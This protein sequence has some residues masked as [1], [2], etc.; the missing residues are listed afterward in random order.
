[1]PCRYMSFPSIHGS[2][3]DL[4]LQTAPSSTKKF[5]K[6]AQRLLKTDHA[7]IADHLITP[8][9][10]IWLMLTDHVPPTPSDGSTLLNYLE[11]TNEWEYNTVKFALDSSNFDLMDFMDQD[12]KLE[13]ESQLMKRVTVSKWEL[14]SYSITLDSSI[15][16]LKDTETTVASR[17]WRMD[18]RIY[19]LKHGPG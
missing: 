2:S 3:K 1:M 9:L 6:G 15:S 13:I 16:V 7:C 14:T 12:L 10:H 5:K 4:V 19:D 8:L 17:L 11:W 18:Q